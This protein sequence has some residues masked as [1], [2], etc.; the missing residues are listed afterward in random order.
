[1]V[2]YKADPAAAYQV[3]IWQMSGRFPSSLRT[4]TDWFVSFLE[5]EMFLLPSSAAL[6]PSSLPFGSYYRKLLQQQPSLQMLSAFHWKR[7]MYPEH[8]AQVSKGVLTWGICTTG[9]LQIYWVLKPQFRRVFKL[10]FKSRCLSTLVVFN[11]SKI[12]LTAE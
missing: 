10:V 6:S 7:Q 9:S 12:T 1:M 8:F 3:F 2:D 11:L 4:A 5:T